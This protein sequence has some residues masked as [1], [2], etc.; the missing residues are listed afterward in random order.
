LTL[1]IR[2]ASGGFLVISANAASKSSGACTPSGT[3]AMPAL[4]ASISAA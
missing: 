4:F 2:I 1:T 3:I